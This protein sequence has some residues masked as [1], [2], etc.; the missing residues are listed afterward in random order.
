MPDEFDRII[1]GLVDQPEFRAAGTVVKPEPF[2]LL[3]DNG[4][5]IQFQ[6]MDDHSVYIYAMD[7]SDSSVVGYKM[8]EVEARKMRNYLNIL[9]GDV[10]DE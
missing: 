10:E 6:P 1:S 3:A 4:T 8:F 9:L 2:T 5:V 7:L